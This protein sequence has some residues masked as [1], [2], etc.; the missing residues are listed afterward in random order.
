MPGKPNGKRVWA[1]L[2]GGLC[3][4]AGS[5]GAHAESYSWKTI[6][7]HGGG[8]VDGFLYHPKQP[9]ILYARTDVGGMY[10]YD[11]AGQ[12]WV[13]LMDGF[14][15]ADWDCFGTMTMAV[16]PQHPDR[17]YATCGLYVNDHAPDG[18][19]IRS[20][21]RG[22][23]WAITRLAGV[24][25][26]GNAMGRGTGERLQVDPANG[27]TLW[28]G[29]N[30]DGLWVSHDRGVTFARAAGYAPKS[31]SVVRIFDSTIYVG[32]GESG[33][34]LYRSLDGGK[35]FARVPGSPKLIPHQM[36]VAA[37]G[38]AFI[39]FADGLGP[40]GVKNGA[41]FK[42]NGDAWT[43]ITPQKPDATT[44]FGYSGLDL[45][46][47]GTLVVSTSCRYASHDDIYVSHD[48]GATW[49]AVGDTARHDLGDHAW[50]KAY[51]GGSDKDAGARNHMGH[52]LD[53]VKIN[54]F[55]PKELIYGTG[56]GVWVAD[57]FGAK[58]TDFA[59]R[60]DN[61]E[62]TVILGLESPPQGP[63]VLMA[64]GDVGGSAFTD[65]TR[66]P[67]DGL[68]TPTNKTNPS[69]AFAAKKPNL[70]VRSVDFEAARGFISQDGAHT[71]T[72]L[73]SAP[74]PIATRDW[75]KHR[76]GK[77]AISAEGTALVWVPEGEGAYFSHDMGQTWTLSQGWPKTERGQE[78]IAD[79]VND[80]IFY[81]YDRASGVAHV[82]RD[83]GRTFT[84]LF[85]IDNSAGGGQLRAVPEHTGDLWLATPSGLYHSVDGRPAK[86]AG[87]TT[88]WQ[89]TFG[90]AAPGRVYPAVFLWGVVG[91]VEG[92]WRSDDTGA[93]WERINDDAHR[94]GQMR[95]IA[96]DPREYGTLYIAPDGRGIMVGKRD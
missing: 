14:G 34:G 13:P 51:M 61:L 27:D 46:P 31:V 83:G 42:L 32:S 73:P 77:I 78:A 45:S 95:A 8:F 87:I 38:T 81:V 26:G 47:D 72:P 63:R 79:T 41:V 91:G 96:G 33:D 55:N 3:L 75:E 60:N 85:T 22:A 20:D 54:P 69:V 28:L 80:A 19:V 23:T 30:R 4:L 18:A 70:I 57:N 9:G 44:S 52:W 94:F 58:T 53:A 11:Y 37:D 67:Q 17:L 88:A 90:K 12:R 29:T 1:G 62:E 24:K 92:L 48:G 71:W 35:T 82:S 59:F 89:V 56:Y 64:A 21:D 2:L 86:M 36:A 43:D 49:R 50:L 39:T 10:R 84:A 66:T 76:A 5:V 16:D 68:F 6:P 93:T 15:K 40:W 25:L 65:L 74:P 7:F